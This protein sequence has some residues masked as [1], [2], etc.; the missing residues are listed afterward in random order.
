M[1]DW[2]S[3]I[4]FFSLPKKVQW[5]CSI[6]SLIFLTVIFLWLWLG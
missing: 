5:G 2:V 1:W 4:I 3:D 6:A